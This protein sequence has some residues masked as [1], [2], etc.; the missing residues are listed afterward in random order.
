MCLCH[1]C[2][3]LKPILDRHDN[4]QQ[5][6]RDTRILLQHQQCFFTVRRLKDI[7]ILLKHCRQNLFPIPLLSVT[8]IFF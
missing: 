4:V 1:M 6:Q 5:H 2:E 3:H 8:T 7:K